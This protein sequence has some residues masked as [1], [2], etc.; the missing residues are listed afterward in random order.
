MPRAVAELPTGGPLNRGLPVDSGIPGYK[1]FSKPVDDIR[2]PDPKDEP[3][4]RVDQADQLLKDRDRV[5]TN[6]TN[7]DKGPP[8]YTDTGPWDSSP[9]TPYPY[10]DDKPNTHNASAEFVAGLWLVQSS[11]EMVLPAGC[12]V[13][14]TLSDIESRL[15][16][17]VRSRAREC[18]STLK[19]ADIKNLRWI[20]SVDCGNGPKVVKLK[21]TRVGNVTKF[22]KLD[23]HVACSCPAWRWQGPEY[24]AK[25]RD[26]QDPNTTLQGTASVPNIR[27]P[28]RVNKVCKHVASVLSLTR[29]WNV[30]RG[31]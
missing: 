13:A 6:E 8:S 25:Q 10:R 3:I 15:N 18:R 12:K 26:Y 27:D 2:T 31:R 24:H 22:T 17:K 14:A 23:L 11:Q 29:S 16:P 1:T 21:G 28:K 7:A 30:P 20:F 19:R 4:E 5:D 9:K